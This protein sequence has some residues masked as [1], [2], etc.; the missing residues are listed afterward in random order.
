MQPNP[1]IQPLDHAQIAALIPHA[2]AMCLLD[3]VLEWDAGRI[4]CSAVSH[5]DPANPMRS[6]DLLPALTG[7]EYAAQAMAVHGGLSGAAGPAGTRPRA[8]YLV[9]LR[10]V[11]CTCARLDDVAEPLQIEAVSVMGDAARVIY[12]F[13]V[14]AG[15]AGAV[16][17][18]LSGRATVV[19]S[20]G[21]ED[22]AGPADPVPA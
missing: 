6:G 2:G 17:E 15:P 3:R 14:K 19:L 11:V 10:D 13:T 16:R 12:E 21:Q 4:R 18:L 8:G 7:I 1:Q 5:T 20:V 22:P 9:G